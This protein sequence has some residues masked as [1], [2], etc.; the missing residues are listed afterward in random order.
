MMKVNKIFSYIII[1]TLL[2]QYTISPVF[3]TVTNEFYEDFEYGAE[4]WTTNKMSVKD[5]VL[6]TDADTTGGSSATLIGDDD[7]YWK[8]QNIVTR[9]S[10]VKSGGWL[11]IEFR[12]SEILL[13]RCNGLWSYQNNSESL[14]YYKDNLLEEGKYYDLYI[15]AEEEK[16]TITLKDGETKLVTKSYTASNLQKGKISLKTSTGANIGIDSIKVTSTDEDFK[17]N[18]SIKKVAMNSYAELAGNENVTQWS[19]SDESIATV[20]DNGKVTGTGVGIAKITAT[21]EH[22]NNAS[23]TVLIYITNEFYEDFENGTGLWKTNNMSVSNGTL[24]TNTSSASGTAKLVGDADCY[25]K[26]QDIKIRFAFEESNSGWTMVKFRESETLLLR[27]SGIWTYQSEEKNLKYFSTSLNVDEFYE[28]NIKAVDTVVSVI[29]RKEDG[30]ELANISYKAIQNEKGGIA[31]QTYGTAIK[32]D[33]VQVT[34]LDED[35]KLNHS[36]KEVAVNSEV[37]L[38]GNRNVV[39]WSSSDESIATVDENGKITGVGVGTVK[40]TATDENENNASCTVLVY[41]DA[42]KAALSYDIAS[43]NV[44][45]SIGES[46]TV[47]PS[48]GRTSNI[49]WESSNE[50]IF[51]IEGKLT[52]R[53][54]I[55]AVSQGSAELI[56]KRTDGTILHR[57]IINVLKEKDNSYTG[58]SY[59]KIK[60]DG[61]KIPDM[62][63]G[64]HT[65]TSV[66]F[67]DKYKNIFK[68]FGF[69]Y[70]RSYESDPLDIQTY[71][72]SNESDIPMMIGLDIVNKT[73]E[74]L[75]TD[76][77]AMRA[78]L[79]NNSTIYVELGNEVYSNANIASADEYI[80]LCKEAYT[81]LKAYA[82]ENN[83]DIKIAVCILG[84]EFNGISSKLGT[85]TETISKN[86]DCFDAVVIHNY[87]TFNS[88][89]GRTADEAMKYTYA[90]NQF[91]K[92]MIEIQKEK[93]PNKEFWYTEYG[94]LILDLFNS[95]ENSEKAR[96]QFG[97]SIGEAVTNAEKILDM[98]ASG[99]IAMCS[100]HCFADPQGFGIVNNGQK[101]PTYYTIKKVSE[102]IN[103]NEYIYPSDEIYSNLNYP[104]NSKVTA[105]FKS[106]A[107]WGLGDAD[108]VNYVVISNRNSNPQEFSL[109]GY[110]LKP[111]WSYGDTKPFGDYLAQKNNMYD[112][113]NVPEPKTY[114]DGFEDA[115]NLD[116][117]SITVCEVNRKQVENIY[118][119]ANNYTFNQMLGKMIIAGADKAEIYQNGVLTDCSL[120]AIDEKCYQVKP[121]GGFE[122]DTDYTIK[123]G[124]KERKFHT[125]PKPEFEKYE[126]T[127]IDDFS[128]NNGDW[129]YSKYRWSVETGQLNK[130]THYAEHTE[131]AQQYDDFVMEMD[132]I[133]QVTGNSET[134]F[135]YSEIS[136]RDGYIRLYISGNI[137]KYFN[138][139]NDV[140]TGKYDKGFTN[141]VRIKI[142]A[143]NNYA[144][145]WAKDITESD[146]T[147]I[148]KIDSISSGPNKIK[149]SGL[150]RYSIDNFK[151]SQNG[152]NANKIVF[153]VDGKKVVRPMG[154][155][156]INADIY[157]ENTVLVGVYDKGILKKLLYLNDYNN[158]YNVD[159]DATVKV[160]VW[161]SLNGMK[162]VTGAYTT[163]DSTFLQR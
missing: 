18:N 15:T 63:L 120:T 143:Y 81:A 44:G 121:V 51:Q 116:G 45:D 11:Q 118:I 20:D 160:F 94:F 113:I 47:S 58:L 92:E 34:S 100:Y 26:N 142:A 35:F 52:T 128:N 54:T 90:N 140:W 137:N 149:L 38:I 95:W 107:L 150:G 125:V 29:L 71:E 65:P 53:K 144:Y 1:I 86:Q 152:S 104:Q 57:N 5:G 49:V 56:I 62:F 73:T 135:K 28:L 40:I 23:C 9:F 41:I 64:I 67:S 66:G 158:G 114:S 39:Q 96:M 112:V 136:F 6:L 134:D 163:I 87:T 126:D 123:V 22:G 138:D 127:T 153:N 21:D 59:G 70:N 19:S 145:V 80:S 4:L 43:L 69:K 60:T 84:E 109:V 103:A 37:E 32:I 27:T 74:E 68:E 75:V 147:Y 79:T 77:A 82:T 119:S 24:V 88:I 124:S 108:N 146:F 132:L 131:Y 141:A 106:V 46:I 133:P 129:S 25:W 115:I 89:D 78:N 50:K 13:I 99:N 155:T 98:A 139:K 91:V 72:L 93:F 36:I 10:F 2:L 85:W 31:F 102:L 105:N 42:E 157:S 161:D 130:I 8:N 162:P 55:K 83:F 97:N 17:L 148:C 117:Y 156:K 122:Y 30:T 154:D 110:E 61:I 76:V 3:A 12:S 101:M 14:L 159:S 16:V 48:N 33:S 151:I 7:C 111:V